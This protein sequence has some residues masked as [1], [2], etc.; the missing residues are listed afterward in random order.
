MVHN[1]HPK[2]NVSSTFI[3]QIQQNLTG[4]FNS[5]TPKGVTALLASSVRAYQV[6]LILNLSHIN[7][8][9]LRK[10]EYESSSYNR[11][12]VRPLANCLCVAAA[13]PTYNNPQFIFFSLRKKFYIVFSR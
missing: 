7:L 8:L 9:T 5:T 12:A 6:N 11:T 3:I 10:A 1:L 4:W 13:T 2:I